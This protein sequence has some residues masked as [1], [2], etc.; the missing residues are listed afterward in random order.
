MNFKEF[1][2]I[3]VSKLTFDACIHRTQDVMVFENTKKG[4]LE[5]LK[6]IKKQTNTEVSTILFVFEHTGLYSHNLSLFLDT[7]TLHFVAISGLEIKRSMGLVRGK[8]DKVDAKRIALYA[9]RRREELKPNKFPSLVIRKLK[10]LLSVRDQLV[11]QRASLRTSFKEMYAI[12]DHKENK[13]LFQVLQRSI[14]SLS[15]EIDLVEKELRLLIKQNEELNNQFELICSVKGVGEQ[16]ALNFIVS[17]EGCTK[18]KTARQFAAY[19]GVAPFPHS[20]GTSIR[21]RNRVSHLANKK[22]K[23]ILSMCAASAIQYSPEMRIYYQQ[24]VEEGK[25]KMC[26]INIIRNKLLHRIFAVINRG[27]PYLEL[28]KYA[29]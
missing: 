13:L 15:K 25:N 1:I 12:L 28:N 7:N 4:Y 3:D 29:A 8:D 26:V 5:L 27:T 9:H 14:K 11:K 21:G 24:R 17:T 10:Q 19:C 23:S 20:S 16:M 2:G 22:L 6:W 18:F